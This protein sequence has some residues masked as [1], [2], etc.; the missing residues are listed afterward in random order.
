MNVH[1][2]TY[3][4]HGV[5]WARNHVREICTWL[6]N[7][8]HPIICLQEVMTSS[9]RSTIQYML[10]R[11]GYQVL[12]PKDEGV[13]WLSSGLLTAVNTTRYKV[14]STCFCPFLQYHNVEVFANKGFFSIWLEDIETGRRFYI[15]NTHTQSDE[16]A[17]LF[18][19]RY[20]SKIRYQQ[21]EQILQHFEG[22]TDPILVVGDLNQ[23]SS[24]H[25]YLQCLHPESS[26]PLK[27]STF[28]HTGED[29]DHVAW[30]PLQWAKDGC[31]FCDIRKKGPQLRFC[32]VHPLPWSDHAPVEV[33][34]L[35]PVLPPERS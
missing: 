21:A 20:L 22:Y 24:I 6:S 11:S 29:L 10:E 31:G 15:V 23:E 27:K 32:R 4:I 8:Y 5:P 1:I 34:L 3:N 16:A 33:E 25:P 12:I 19:A 13:T 7:E 28:F 18:G 30:L 9:G 14:L 2:L 17:F 35:I 26:L